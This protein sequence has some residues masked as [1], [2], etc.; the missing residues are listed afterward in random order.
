ML[1]TKSSR[2]LQV[3]VGARLVVDEGAGDAVAHI[4]LLGDALVEGCDAGQ[5]SVLASL[6]R[7]DSCHRS[8]RRQTQAGDE[9]LH[10]QVNISD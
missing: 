8:S 5:V 7:V 6:A 2:D 3:P 1:S 4:R 10:S 9:V